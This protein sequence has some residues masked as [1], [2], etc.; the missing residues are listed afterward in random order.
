MPGVECC[1]GENVI[2]R[3][4]I[5]LVSGAS[6]GIGSSIAVECA[7]E[8]AQVWLG[9]YR[10]SAGAE[11]VQTLISDQSREASAAQKVVLNVSDSASCKQGVQAIL[12]KE[13]RIDALISCAGVHREGPLLGLSDLDVESQLDVNLKGSIFLSREV[14]NPMVRQ[15]SGSIVFLGSVSAHRM[16]R[17]HAV[18]SATKAGLE[19]FTRALASEVAKRSIRVNCL[20]PGPVPSSMLQKSVDQTGDDPAARVPL[21]RLIQAQEVARMTVFLASDQSSAVT[22]ASIPVDG[23]YLLW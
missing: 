9:Y 21:G 2:L 22:G 6:G 12:E 10:N 11:K 15:R 13:G 14:L 16:T 5:I 7:R 23:G 20:L 8:G 19:G 3:G 18:Y 17:G 1:D 4:K